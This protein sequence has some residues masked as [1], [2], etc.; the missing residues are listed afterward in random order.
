[1]DQEDRCLHRRTACDI[2]S[3]EWQKFSSAAVNNMNGCEAALLFLHG[4][5]A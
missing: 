4:R 5:R 3:G 1:M 2:S